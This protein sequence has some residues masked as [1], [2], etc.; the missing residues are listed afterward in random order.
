MVV[1]HIS[2]S[3]GM[4]ISETTVKSLVSWK[5]VGL[6]LR[7]QPIISPLGQESRLDSLKT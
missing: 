1:E 3:S 4:F 6:Y 2:N 7:Q 5:H